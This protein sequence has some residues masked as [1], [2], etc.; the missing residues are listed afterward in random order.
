MTYLAPIFP[1]E[2][3]ENGRGRPVVRITITMSFLSLNCVSG[4]QGEVIVDKSILVLDFE[5]SR[6]ASNTS[7]DGHVL[8]A[9]RVSDA[10]VIKIHERR[11]LIDD[12]S[13]LELLR[14]IVRT[15][16]TLYNDIPY[17]GDN[18]ASYFAH[19]HAEIL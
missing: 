17:V 3:P 19:I 6:G 16:R 9:C 13:T 18:N 5:S 1:S 12:A 14:E 11:L 7:A 2:S 4:V 15:C 8:V 10:I